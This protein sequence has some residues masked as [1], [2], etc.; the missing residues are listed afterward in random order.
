MARDTFLFRLGIAI[1]ATTPAA[2]AKAT[3]IPDSTIRKYLAGSSPSI[4]NAALLAEALGVSLDWLASMPGAGPMRP[5]P[6]LKGRHPKWWSDTAV[7]DLVIARYRNRTQ[8]EVVA[9]ASALFG[10][11]RAPSRSSVGRIWQRFDRG[12]LIKGGL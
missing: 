5:T 11:A 9:E 10:A 6:S 7:R 4:E 1:G 8:D 3:G 12:H 2:L